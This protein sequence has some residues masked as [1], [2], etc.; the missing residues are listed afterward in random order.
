MKRFPWIHLGK[1]TDPELPYEPPIHLGD[2]SNG[3][4]FLEQTPREKKLRKL[5]LDTCDEK[6][7]HLG[8]D[9]REFIASTMGMATTLSV[10]NMAAGC[11]SSD[12]A[13]GSGGYK[14]SPDATVDQDH[15]DAALHGEYFILDLQTHHVE[16]EQHWRETHP[17][18]TYSGDTVAQFLTF[19]ACPDLQTDPIKCVDSTKYVE[20]I[21]LG[22]ETTVAVLSG[23][24]GAICDDA[25]MCTHPVSNED[26]VHSRDRVNKAAGC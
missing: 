5:I 6:A 20:N 21:F 22:S 3:E 26:M 7:R 16:D 10:L 4:F 23:F 12:A 1:K 14:V 13:G 19:Y 2:L 9:R 17:G 25:T 24:P 8:M 11:S 15:A 18:Q